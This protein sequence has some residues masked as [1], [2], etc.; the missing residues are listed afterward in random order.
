MYKIKLETNGSEYQSRGETMLEA[1]DKLPLTWENIK[2]KGV[3]TFT[4]GKNKSSKLMYLKPLRMLFASKLR[5]YGWAKQF[6][7]LLEA[8]KKL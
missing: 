6:E 4:K 3:I 7:T 5:R 8:N 2:A 1:L